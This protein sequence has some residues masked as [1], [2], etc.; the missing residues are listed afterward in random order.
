[1]SRSGK[2]STLAVLPAQPATITPEAAAALGLDPCV[3]GVSYAFE[4]VPTDVEVGQDG[5]LYVT[6]LPGGPE[7]A[8]L[9]ARGKVYKV[10]PWNGRVKE[11]ASGLLGATNLALSGGRIYVTE[12]FAGRIARVT[13]GKVGEFLSLPGVVSIEAGPRGSLYAGTGLSGAPSVVRI[14]AR[15]KGW[16]S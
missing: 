10:N 9:G 14:E 3:G 16:K 12:F 4:A 2:I 5:F 7:S 8:A 13:H 6:V 15:S 1:V 11:I